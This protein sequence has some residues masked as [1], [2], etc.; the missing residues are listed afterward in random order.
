M[1]WECALPYLRDAAFHLAAAIRRIP[2]L[3]ALAAVA[4]ASSTP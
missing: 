3:F 2:F 1:M 4:A